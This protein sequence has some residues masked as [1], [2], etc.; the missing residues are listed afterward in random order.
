MAAPEI[1]KPIGILSDGQ[2]AMMTAESAN[3]LGVPV[4]VLGKEGSPASHTSKI[5]VGDYNSAFDQLNFSKLVQSI[6]LDT[7]HVNTAGLILLDKEGF[8]IV[9]PPKFT[10]SLQKRI[11]QRFLL[12]KAGIPIVAWAPVESREELNNAYFHLGEDVIVKT[13]EGGYDGR[14]NR[15]VDSVDK[16]EEAWRDFEGQQLV[17]EKR[18][19]FKKEIAT[20]IGED[21]YGG[22]VIFPIVQSFH[23]DGMLDHTFFPS[24]EGEEVEKQAREFGG[25]LLD[26]ADGPALLGVEMFVD[27]ANQ[28]LVNEF[29]GRTHN[30]GHWT[31][32]GTSISQFDAMVLIASGQHLVEPEI[33][34]PRATVLMQNL[35]GGVQYNEM[36]EE[37]INSIQRD[38]AYPHWYFKTPR[39][40]F[41]PRK[42]GHITYFGGDRDVLLRQASYS[43]KEIGFTD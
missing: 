13:S 15:S 32:E 4:L 36:T 28:V 18:I 31:I 17:V 10:K 8:Q 26:A 23:E 7:D 24:G 11:D 3:K 25:K 2:L 20:I 43:I 42:R 38:W 30:T 5:H 6:N 14:G 1:Q 41:P 39:E 21:I 12:E 22:R 40:Q 35:N 16:L 34:R 37:H 29:A 9:P 19:P 27:Q 33:R